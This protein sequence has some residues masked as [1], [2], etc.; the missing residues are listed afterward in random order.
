MLPDVLVCRINTRAQNLLQLT[1]NISFKN[2]WLAKHRCVKMSA[3]I[4]TFSYRSPGSADLLCFAYDEKQILGMFHFYCIGCNAANRRA[5]PGGVTNHVSPPCVW[6]TP[7]RP[8]CY[9]RNAQ[10]VSPEMPQDRNCHA[11]LVW[12]GGVNSWADGIQQQPPCSGIWGQIQIEIDTGD[13]ATMR[14][15]SYRDREVLPMTYSSVF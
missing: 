13:N 14:A 5:S 6:W 15:S 10:V 8:C 1:D 11:N 4:N 12:L 9:A 3:Q 7:T 2:N